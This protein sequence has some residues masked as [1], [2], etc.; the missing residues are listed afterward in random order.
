MLRRYYVAML[1]KLLR[2][3]SRTGILVKGGATVDE[4]TARSVDFGDPLAGGKRVILCK[5]EGE[6]H[7]LDAYCPHNEGGQIQSGP[8]AQGKFAVCPLHRYL[9]DPKTGKAEGVACSPARRY[10]TK[11]D[12]DDLEVFI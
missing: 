6:V 12:G 7:A 8:L 5:V 4:G 1:Q 10:K 9:F 3:F 2:L 11:T